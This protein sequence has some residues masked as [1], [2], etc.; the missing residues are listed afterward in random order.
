MGS[1]G[2]ATSSREIGSWF[3]A[4]DDVSCQKD[5]RTANPSSQA[6]QELAAILFEVLDEVFGLGCE[7][8]RVLQHE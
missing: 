2:H 3:G 6:S 5:S 1:Y 8:Q 7:L 4:V